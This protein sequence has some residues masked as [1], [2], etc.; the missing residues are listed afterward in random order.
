MRHDLSVELQNCACAGMLG[1]SDWEDLL[2][3]V[4]LAGVNGG[5]LSGTLR[6]IVEMVEAACLQIC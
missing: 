4:E 1:G 5:I 6:S 3:Q 2:A